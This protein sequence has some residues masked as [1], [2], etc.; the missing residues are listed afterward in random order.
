MIGAEH[1]L[2][3]NGIH[4]P[5][6]APDRH[7]TTCPQCSASRT[8]AHRALKCLGVTI[9]ADGSVRWGCNHCGWTGPSKG[10]GKG[11]GKG[12]GGE[13]K[14]LTSYVYRDKGGAILFR[15]VRNA[16]GR[17]PRFFLQKWTG[18]EWARGTSGV[19]TS[20][21]YRADE[22]AKAITDGREVIVAEGEKDVDR[23]WAL[24]FA[25]TCNA[26]G[27][28]EPG[29]APKW[30]KKHSDQLTGAAIV[31]LNDHDAPGVAHAQA[32]CKLS[33]GVAKSVK[34]LHLA[35]HWPDIS[36]GGDV[37]DWLDHGGGTRDK[38]ATL[39]AGVT[40]APA[41]PKATDDDAE[42]ARLARL[43]TIEY[44][45]ARA[46]AAKRLGYRTAILDRLVASKRAELDGAPDG[47]PGRPITFDEIEPWEEPVDG[48]ELLTSISEAIGKYVV[49][50]E[51]QRDAAALGV[52]F[53]HTHNLRDT[54]PIF[55]I[56][57]PTRRCG[58]TRLE[59]VV[60]RMVPRPLMASSATPAFLARVIEKHRPTVLIDEY[61]A[62]VGG[63]PAMAETLRGQL[64][65][66]F[67]RDGAKIG[68][69][70]P[71]PGGGYEER[72]FSTWAANWIAGIKK[73]P[74]TVEDRSVVL[75]LKRK[76]PGE[77]VARFRGADGAELGVLRRQIA[78]FIIDNER[79]LREIEPQAPSALDAAGDRAADAWDPLFAIAD[80]AGGDWPRRARAAALA[81]SG[82]DT[83]A[84]N[85]SGV[86]VELLTDIAR[87]LA[88][89]DALGPTG[90]QMKSD[91]HIAVQALEAFKPEDDDDLVRRNHVKPRRIAGIGSE[92]IINAL[93]T[94]V[95]RRWPAWDKGKPIRPH[96]LA[97]L[98]RAYGVISQPLRDDGELLR[99]YPR[100][101]L[102]DAIQRYLR[103]HTLY[104]PF[105]TRNNVTSLE[106]AG[107]NEVFESVTNHACY[108]CT[109]AENAKDSVACD[110]V[111]PK[112]GGDIGSA[113]RRPSQTPTIHSPPAA[114]PP[115]NANQR[116]TNRDAPAYEVLGPA[117]PGQRCAICDG[118]LGVRRIKYAGEE[119]VWHEACAKRRLA[120]VAGKPPE[121]VVAA[122]R[123]AGV[124]FQLA[125]EG[126]LFTLEWRGPVDPVI[127]E[128]IR[129]NYE[130]ILDL[131]RR[132]AGVQ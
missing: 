130:V 5:S 50:D 85:D 79:R 21:L 27:A 80:V 128:A 98:L 76:L 15:K 30:T 52:V 37:S 61:D 29:K 104:P 55:F 66:S 95:E 35:D 78:R 89:C 3:E 94:F 23:L 28:S 119:H 113:R 56:V 121:V 82:V 84:L 75:R 39:I 72:E 129:A 26:H 112:K 97:R 86:D 10:K 107:E 65:S 63:D 47:L 88:A 99:G 71:L 18:L 123:E 91:K 67:D 81:L 93:V 115:I 17:E 36:A 53:A 103:A 57:S 6:Y 70:V 96:Q 46:D 44:E 74:E 102:D 1:V 59:R 24:G 32:V 69:C 62:T 92:Q 12:D 16:P 48:A 68:K 4:L 38:L 105:S 41:E 116:P 83:G 7:Y 64:N 51:H 101:R 87:I 19:D 111:T 60:K 40:D 8:Q 110:A 122:A 114:N 124:V 58:K 120:T 126:D 127:D 25:A 118:S 132:E 131:L 100:D 42:L 2:N 22:L 11:K 108:T 109:T 73:I 106:N 90:E 43:P 125:P 33:L 117:R 13:G 45:R 31:V 49:M 77:K 54:A 20:I 9:D 14:P 34:R